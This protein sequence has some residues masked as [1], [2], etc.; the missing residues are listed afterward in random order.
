LEDLAS[1]GSIVGL[2][3]SSRLVPAPGRLRDAA[4]LRYINRYCATV[5]AGGW[6]PFIEAPVSG[7]GDP[8]AFDLVMVSRGVR[9]AHEFITRL[10]DVQAQVRPILR[11]AGDA[12]VDALVLVVADTHANRTA[13][14]EAGEAMR[15][16][17]PRSG[18][19]ILREMRAGR[20][21]TGNGLVFLRAPT[22]RQ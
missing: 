22:R 12:A 15:A 10:R 3:F 8:R 11:K 1:I 4:Q 9:V 18:R 16:A 20:C 6:R 7:G 14:R 5:A 2:G 21:P 19:D 13:V 17:F